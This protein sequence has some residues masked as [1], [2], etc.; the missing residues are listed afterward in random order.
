MPRRK[1]P[2]TP[3]DLPA[4]PEGARKKG[5]Y[6]AGDK[7]YF[8]RKGSMQLAD[9]CCACGKQL[10]LTQGSE[11]RNGTVSDETS[12]TSL[13]VVGHPPDTLLLGKLIRK[14]DPRRCY[15]GGRKYR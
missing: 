4:I 13:P 9:K 14:Q 12:S 15:W 1:Q 7:V 8:C 2:P 5:Y 6:V 3:P 11:W 10:T